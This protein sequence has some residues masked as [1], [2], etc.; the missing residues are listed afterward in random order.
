MREGRDEVMI[1]LKVLEVETGKIRELLKEGKGPAWSPGKGEHIAYVGGRSGAAEEIWIVKSDGANPRKLAVGGFPSWGSDPNTV[2]YHSRKQGKLMKIRIDLEKPE[3]VE[4]MPMSWWYPA[5]SLDGRHVACRRGPEVQVM[6]LGT[7]K[8]VKRL[9][10]AAGRG[11]LGGWSPDGR[12]LCYG[13][14]G[15]HDVI[16]LHLADLQTAQGIPP[17][18]G[19]FHD[20][21]LVAGRIEDRLRL[22]E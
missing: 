1:G 22:P 2:F 20:G 16:G 6:D 19:Q 3:P 21:G 10:L 12:Y 13:G 4:V 5:V 8:I 11:F 14:Y 17:F 7:K 18:R 9:P 15:G